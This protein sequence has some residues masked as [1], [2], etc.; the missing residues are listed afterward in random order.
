M[1]FTQCFMNPFFIL[2]T[3]IIIHNLI[4][5]NVTKKSLVFLMKLMD[6]YLKI[7]YDNL[8]FIINVLD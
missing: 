4:V 6:V 3:E 1:L 5:F 7:M 8:I 2:T